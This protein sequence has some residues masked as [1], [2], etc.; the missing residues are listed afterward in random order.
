MIALVSTSLPMGGSD[1]FSNVRAVS[2]V[3]LVVGSMACVAA[4]Y[5]LE[6]TSQRSSVRDFLHHRAES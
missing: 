1:M 2:T 4:L 3:L 6:P 5:T